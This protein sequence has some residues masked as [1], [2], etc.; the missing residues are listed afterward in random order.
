MQ[1]LIPFGPSEAAGADSSGWFTG[2][3]CDGVFNLP[4]IP[5]DID[6]LHK[7]MICAD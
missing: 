7:V 2:V 3:T 5:G 4:T 6:I 1:L